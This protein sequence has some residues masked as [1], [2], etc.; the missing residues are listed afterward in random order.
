MQTHS[1]GTK[2]YG[3]KHFTVKVHGFKDISRRLLSLKI[4]LTPRYH[5]HTARAC[6]FKSYSDKKTSILRI[7][8]TKKLNKSGFKQLVMAGG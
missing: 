1:V 5:G 6:F 2:V 7:I 4:I 8:A 3:L